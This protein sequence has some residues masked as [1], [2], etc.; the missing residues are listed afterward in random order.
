MNPS[1]IY[2]SIKGYKTGSIYEMKS[3]YDTVIQGMSGLMTTTGED[4]PP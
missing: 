3:A 4:R 1:I 2:C